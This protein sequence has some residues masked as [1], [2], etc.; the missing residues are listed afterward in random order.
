[1]HQQGRPQE[2]KQQQQTPDRPAGRSN[3]FFEPSSSCAI[4]LPDS[5]GD[6]SSHPLRLGTNKYI[7]ETPKRRRD[8]K[9]STLQPISNHTE[10]HKP[11]DDRPPS[12]TPNP[13][14]A[15][16]SPAPSAR[17]ATPKSATLRSSPPPRAS[18]PLPDRPGARVCPCH[19]SSSTAGNASGGCRGC[20]TSAGLGRLLPLLLRR[21]QSHPRLG[22]RAA[23][24]RGRLGGDEGGWGAVRRDGMIKRGG[25]TEGMEM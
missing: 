21:R 15:T 18:P 1:M 4:P 20:A 19:S 23:A 6:Q 10:S 11:S 25:R 13:K 5:E 14:C 16:P 8:R 3:S 17:S 7:P 9:R 24:G 12:K 22:R 2:Q